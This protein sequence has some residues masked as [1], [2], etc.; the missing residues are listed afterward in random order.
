[1]ASR[2]AV[3][4]ATMHRAV[5]RRVADGLLCARHGRGITVIRPGATALP[6]TPPA[7]AAV[8][9]PWPGRK[10]DWLARTVQ[11]DITNGLY[12]PGAHLPR[13]KQLCSAYGVGFRTLKA[14]LARLADAR[15]IAPWGRG[16]RVPAI[17]VSPHGSAILVVAR[18]TADCVQLVTERTSECMA[19]LEHECAS[20]GL[21]LRMAA[22]SFQGSELA[23]GENLARVIADGAERHGVLGI[24]FFGAAFDASLCRRLVGTLVR[25]GAPVAVIDEG[26]AADLGELPAGHRTKVIAMAYGSTCGE[27]VGRMLAQLGHH[28]VAY[29]TAYGDAPWSQGRYAGVRQALRALESDH[30]VRLVPI[31]A[32]EA[33][34][35]DRE[36]RN[37]PLFGGASRLLRT[38]HTHRPMLLG[39][40]WPEQQI[41]RLM[42]SYRPWEDTCGRLSQLLVDRSVTAWVADNDMTALTC[43]SFLASRRVKVPEQVSV[44]GFDDGNCALVNNLT[45]Y[46]FNCRAVMLAAL[47]HLLSPQ[48]RPGRAAPESVEIEG[49]VAQRRSTGPARAR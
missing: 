3:A 21:A 46:N 5:K 41:V 23:Y 13:A 28:R 15:S 12:G 10:T 49:H 20:R 11:R 4:K 45:S 43:L 1:M 32:A 48:N 35:A 42:G 37:L 26:N 18:G 16:Y 30:P 24:V 40:L 6:V 39:L 44:A 36:S 8:A 47:H 7:V 25:C 14:A 22:V 33:S 34:T 17:A 9:T 29:V 19:A 31:R 27:T 38:M 2:A